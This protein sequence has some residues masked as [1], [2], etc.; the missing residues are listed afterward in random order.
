MCDSCI[1]SANRIDGT[2]KPSST[3]VTDNTSR[4][5]HCCSLRFVSG[6]W[7]PDDGRNPDAEILGHRDLPWVKKKCPCF[8]ARAEY[9]NLQPLKLEQ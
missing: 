9:A 1:T 3:F 7:F 2:L 8:D 6:L 5:S 4:S